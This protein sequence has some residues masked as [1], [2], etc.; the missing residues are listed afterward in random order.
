MSVD[1]KKVLKIDEVI[2]YLP[3]RYPFLMIDRVI[4]YQEMSLRAVKN[5][6]VNEPCFTG[7]FPDNP[8]MPGVL[9]IESLAQAGAVLAYLKTQSS[10]RDNLFYLA[11]IDG[12][13]FKQ[14]VLPGDQLVLDVQIVGNKANF[15]KI[16]GEATVDGKI[17]CSVDILSAMKEVSS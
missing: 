15:W 7:H 17:V 4:D 3:H 16:H 5:V 12:A 14:M 13:K 10:P 1:N 9:I 8:V 2:K 11:G 6:T